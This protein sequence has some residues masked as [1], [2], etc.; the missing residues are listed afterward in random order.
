M[1]FDTIVASSFLLV[2]PPVEKIESQL[3]E[4]ERAWLSVRQWLPC[5]GHGFAS[6]VGR[7]REMSGR[8][9]AKRSCMLTVVKAKTGLKVQSR[10]SRN[11]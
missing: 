1:S 6:L 10:R 7:R 3:V 5:E 9:W 11:T 4:I 8:K 2:T